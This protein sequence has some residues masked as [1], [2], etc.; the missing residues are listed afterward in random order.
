MESND[1]I[2]V[3][4]GSAGCVLANR[5]SA[6]PQTRVL[7][8]EAGGK[9]S[10]F[11]ISMPKGIAKLVGDPKHTW[12]FPVDQPREPGGPTSEVWVRGKVLG[13]SSSIN[14]MIYVRGQPE[15][16]DAWEAAGAKG[17]GWKEMGAAFR[18]IEDH[19]LGA[20]S[21]RG[22]GGPV[23]IS[24]ASSIIPV[25]RRLSVPAKKWA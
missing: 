5:L 8:L 24:T 22:A 9:D 7:L 1:Y 11:L 10:S 18:Q 14:G 25:Q 12:Y 13:G 21:F 6:D 23:R 15:D 19:E 16:Y 20:S 3:G 2:I 4:A 17:W